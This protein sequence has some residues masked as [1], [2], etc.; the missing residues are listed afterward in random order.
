[1]GSLK[2]GQYPSIHPR[3]FLS[4]SRGAS[5]NIQRFHLGNVCTLNLTTWVFA[6]D[7]ANLAY[8]P[9]VEGRS[10][11]IETFK[12]LLAEEGVWIMTK[13]LSARI[14]SATPTSVLIVVG[15]ETLK[16]LSLRAELIESRHWWKKVEGDQDRERPWPRSV[17]WVTATICQIFLF[18]FFF[19]TRTKTC[20]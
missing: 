12:Q 3:F 11:I 5:D 20:F 4:G 2:R 1:M 17:P 14:M 10:S 9:Q 13:G 8:L 7:K 16:R 15:Y 6:P 19:S 18:F